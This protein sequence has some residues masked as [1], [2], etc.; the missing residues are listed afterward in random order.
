[1]SDTQAPFE[2]DTSTGS[3]GTTAQAVI[4]IIRSGGIVMPFA[5]ALKSWVGWSSSAGGGTIDVGLFKFT[6][7]RNDASTVSPV[8]MDNTQYTGLGNTKMEDFA[9][10]SFTVSAFAAGDILYSAVKG[11]INAKTWYLLSTLEVEWT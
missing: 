6:P 10:T 3:A 7:A 11:S 4:V 9:E 1:M 8:L 2:H 5:G